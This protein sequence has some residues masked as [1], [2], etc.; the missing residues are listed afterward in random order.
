MAI[1]GT[2]LLL[3]ARIVSLDLRRVVGVVGVHRD[4]AGVGDRLLDR[5][6]VEHG[7]LEHFAGEAPVGREIDE[8]GAAFVDGDLLQPLEREWL[9]ARH[10]ALQPP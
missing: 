10:D 4:G 5:L 3:S 1:T 9:P 7:L 6:G 2:P 8:H